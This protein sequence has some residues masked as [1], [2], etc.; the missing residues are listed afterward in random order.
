VS[1]F[2]SKNSAFLFYKII[3][4]AMIQLSDHCNDA[5]WWECLC[6]EGRFEFESDRLWEWGERVTH[7]VGDWFKQ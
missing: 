5:G 1:Y 4:K 7:N 2:R 3:S 6:G